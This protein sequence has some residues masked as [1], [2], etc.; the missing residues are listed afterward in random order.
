MVE[1]IAVSVFAL[2]PFRSSM[3]TAVETR[4]VRM[5]KSTGEWPLYIMGSRNAMIKNMVNA[6]LRI[7]F[8]PFPRPTSTIHTIKTMPVIISPEVLS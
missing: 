1:A 6:R 3:E 4:I 5:L 2:Y 7:L 8:T